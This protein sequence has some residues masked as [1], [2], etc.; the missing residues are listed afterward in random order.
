MTTRVCENC[1]AFDRE[2]LVQHAAYVGDTRIPPSARCK[3]TPPPWHLV[4]GNDW[5][6]AWNA[7]A[8][9]PAALHED[10]GA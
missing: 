8:P 1:A 7:R 2:H 6:Q 5:C 9:R 10:N 4:R 3:R